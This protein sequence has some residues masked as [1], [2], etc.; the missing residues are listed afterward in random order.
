MEGAGKL[1]API[2]RSVGEISAPSQHDRDEAAAAGGAPDRLG[3]FLAHWPCL[4][5]IEQ[6]P[7][8]AP[9]PAPDGLRILA[10]NMERC[11]RVEETATVI[12]HAGADLVLA[13]EMDI[14]MA[15]S[16]QRQ[17]PRD[18]AASLG[19]AHAFGVEF[20]ELGI[21]DPQETQAHMGEANRAGLHGNAILSRYPLEEV[22]LLPLDGGGEWYLRNPMNDGQLRVGGRMALAATIN[23]A[24]GPITAAVVHLESVSTPATR[25]RQIKTLLEALEALWPV[26]PMVIGGDL[27]TIGFTEA[28]MTGTQCL[29]APE[30]A[31]PCFT[32]LAA[33]G[34]AW[35]GANTAAFTTRPMPGVP[36]QYPMKK[37]DWLFVRGL[38]ASDPACIPAVSAT[39]QYLS[40]HEAIGARV[41]AAI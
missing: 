16:G 15:R 40:D 11:K 17:T 3:E 28:G 38:L 23:L 18:L 41:Q 19:F 24:S 1:R 20:V 36:A 4:N 39:G 7:A 34:Y 13:S 12:Q 25:N 31:E 21:G 33:H 2:R 35:Q 5:E 29:M 27:N 37:L 30:A 8:P 10:W 22:T 14:G 6:S 9:T 26:R 32:T